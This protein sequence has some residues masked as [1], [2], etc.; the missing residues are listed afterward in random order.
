VHWIGPLSQE[1]RRDIDGLLNRRVRSSWTTVSF[2]DANQIADAIHAASTHDGVPPDLVVL[3]R[4]GG[5]WRDWFVLNDPIVVNAVAGARR[6]I[7]TAVGHQGDTPAITS[8]GAGNFNTPTDIAKAVNALLYGPT[9]RRAVPR[10]ETHDEQVSRQVRQAQVEMTELRQRVATADQEAAAARHRERTA[11]S[12]RDDARRQ[13]QTWREH[14]VSRATQQA[15]DRIQHRSLRQAAATIV[16]AGG[17]IAA[18]Q[19]LDALPWWQLLLA[20]AGIC[21]IVGVTI[22]A[23]MTSQNRAR[24]PLRTPATEPLRGTSAWF[25]R[26]DAVTSPRQLRQLLTSWEKR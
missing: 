5:S 7:V 10:T 12:E 22:R 20:D 15:L 23:L 26:I 24:R 1:T 6:P 4:G 21:I 17:T 9:S 19:L 18:L 2:R 13:T 11:I 16:V 25:S 3:F 8:V 14:C